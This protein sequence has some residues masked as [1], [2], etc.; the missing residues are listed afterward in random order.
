MERPGQMRS[1]KR[2]ARTATIEHFDFK[3]L[4][5]HEVVGRTDAREKIQRLGVAAHQHVL[6]VIDEVPAFGIRK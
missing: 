1:S 4:V 5:K 3:I 2:R 6:A